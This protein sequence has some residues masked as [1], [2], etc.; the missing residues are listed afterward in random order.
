MIRSE[1]VDLITM[2]ISVTARGISVGH[3]DESRIA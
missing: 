2:S 3:P 1:D